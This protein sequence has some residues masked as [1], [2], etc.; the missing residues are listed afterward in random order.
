[1]NV[2]MEYLKINKRF[3]TKYMKLVLANKYNRKIA[4]E[5][6]KT[7][8]ENRYSLIDEQ[9]GK[10]NLKNEILKALDNLKK[11]LIKQDKE[12]KDIVEQTRLYYNYVLYFDYVINSKSI[13]KIIIQIAEKKYQNLGQEYSELASAIYGE[14]LEN[15]KEMQDFIKRFQS[16]E[17]NLEFEKSKNKPDIKRTTIKQNIKFPLLYSEYAI[18]KA[19]ETEPIS[20]DILFV[21]YH[22]IASA[23]IN[24]ITKGNVKSQYI[25]SL[26]VTVLSKKQKAKRVLDILNSE[27]MKYKITFEI[28]YK[29]FEKNK[30]KIY[31]LISQGYKF[32]VCIENENLKQE[33]IKRL[34][35]FK[36][37]ITDENTSKTIEN[38]NLK[39]QI[40]K[41]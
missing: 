39:T 4:E 24:D 14:F 23:V 26:P 12:T 2:M 31:D 20:E 32:A 41:F 30:A 16:N 27:F 15:Q 10:L 7:Y 11:D 38:S 17:F 9:L 25:A 6:Y 21:E 3:V 29:N 8:V 1:M 36:Y 18:A 40:I 28:S 22:L 19:M 34:E 33:D 37:I 35:V 13:E 5:F